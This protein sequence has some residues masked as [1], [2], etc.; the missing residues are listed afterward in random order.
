[1]GIVE[2][3]KKLFSGAGAQDAYWIYVRCD[4]CQE[5]LKA[6]VD[7]AHDLTV[8]YDG[9]GQV[10]GY[11]TRKTIIGSN[12]CFNQIETKVDFDPR[13]RPLAHEI[14]GGQLITKE[15]Y[16]AAHADLTDSSEEK[17]KD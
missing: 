8:R 14:S 15:D 16:E 13:R 11:F 5:V 4:R 12:Q 1:M 9:S 3:L 7:L 10:A 2:R 17:T 6:R